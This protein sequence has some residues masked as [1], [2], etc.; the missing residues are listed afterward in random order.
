MAIY[1]ANGFSLNMLDIKDGEEVNVNVSIHSVSKERV[2]TAVLDGAV[3]VIGH[4]DTAK[5]VE[6]DL[7]VGVDLYNRSTIKLVKGDI[8]YIAQYIGPRLEEGVTTL[9]ENARIEYFRV[10]IS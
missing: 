2:R 1:L 10:V 7:E 3:S 8:V 6:N 9:P 4:R 5:I